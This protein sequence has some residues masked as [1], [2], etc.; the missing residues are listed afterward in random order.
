MENNYLKK[1]INIFLIII[2]LLIYIIIIFNK[3]LTDIYQSSI[4]NL[5][6]YAF[7]LFLLINIKIIIKKYCKN[8][9]KT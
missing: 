7:L 3:F 6:L 5:D 2:K 1:I 4:K 8:L 9:N